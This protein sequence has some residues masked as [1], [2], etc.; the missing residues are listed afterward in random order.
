MSS[1]AVY[2]LVAR[3][4]I[5]AQTSSLLPRRRGPN[6]KR[7]RL[8]DTR[9]RVIDEAIE[10]RY[11]VRPR[12]P[13]EEVYRNVKQRCRDLSLPAPARGSVLSRIRALDARHVAR[14]R[15]GSKAA[16]AIARSTPGELEASSALELIQN[17]SHAGGRDYRRFFAS[18]THR[19][20][21]AIV[22]H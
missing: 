11:L 3:Y 7:R 9:E 6:K 5:S 4:R 20:P 12:T 18:T 13:M 17:G 10:P 22:D 1:R 15:L 14:R 21:L 19:A 8:G 2:R 16:Q